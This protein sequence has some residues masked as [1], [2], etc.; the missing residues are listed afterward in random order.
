LT[1]DFSLGYRLRGCFAAAAKNTCDANGSEP[2]H[3]VETFG[4]HDFRCSVFLPVE[5]PAFSR[6]LDF[7]YGHDPLRLAPF[8][9]AS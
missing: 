8:P 1:F 9:F 5:T 6:G 2:R 4:F 7:D 3:A